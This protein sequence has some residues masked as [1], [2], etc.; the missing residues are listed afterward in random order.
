MDLPLPQA[1]SVLAFDR[2]AAQL[3]PFAATLRSAVPQHHAAIVRHIVERVVVDDRK[4]R[5]VRVRL[6]ARPA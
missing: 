4:V 1:S 3:L 2:A 5:E 6:E